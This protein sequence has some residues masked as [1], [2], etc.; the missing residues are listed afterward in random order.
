[1]EFLY[2]TTISR[3]NDK[4]EKPE[5]SQSKEPENP[6]ATLCD[7]IPQCNPTVHSEFL[8]RETGNLIHTTWFNGSIFKYQG[9]YFLCYRTDQ[10]KWCTH[11]R[12]HLVMVNDMF[13][14]VGQNITLDT[15]ANT[16]GWRVDYRGQCN[17]HS[18]ARAEDPR[19]L[20]DGLLIPKIWYT[21]G[22]KMYSGLLLIECDD[23]GL[24][25]AELSNIRSPKPPY[26]DQHWSDPKYDGREKNWSPISGSVQ[27]VIYSYS[28]FVIYD[29]TNERIVT[30]LPMDIK[31]KHGFIKGG[32]PA[33]KYGD[34]YLTIFHS[35]KRIGPRSVAYYYAGA[36]VLDKD[37]IPVRVSRYPIIAPYPDEDHCRHNESYVVFPCGLIVEDNLIYISYGYNDHSIKIHA[38]THRELEYNL[39]EINE[40]DY[41]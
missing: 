5:I 40:Y 13:R 21:D 39:R 14:P 10:Y 7:T 3:S 2:M 27:L 18:S 19:V 25:H 22:F 12:V 30:N 15:V 23:N 41:C 17:D 38:M 1:M 26:I 34:G 29:T 16:N 11:P 9:R 24:K 31:W 6:G 37:L 8:K 28:P 35:S 32:T 33:V 20:S 4:S 36:L